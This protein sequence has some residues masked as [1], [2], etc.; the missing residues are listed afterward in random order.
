MCLRTK[1]V[2]MP[3]GLDHIEVSQQVILKGKGWFRK[4]ITLES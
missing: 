1:W 4:L 2:A 3:K